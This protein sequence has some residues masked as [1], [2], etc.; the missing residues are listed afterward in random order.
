M[1]N[2]TQTHVRGAGASHA[3]IVNAADEAGI[4]VTLF[5]PGCNLNARFTNEQAKAIIVAI[6]LAIGETA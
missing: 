6:Q 2:D 5:G 4:S 1:T 3:V